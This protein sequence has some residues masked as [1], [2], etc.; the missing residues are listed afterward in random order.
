MKHLETSE[1]KSQQ[2][3]KKSSVFWSKWS[4]DCIIQY[5]FT[6]MKCKRK[7]PFALNLKLSK[8]WWKYDAEL[9]SVISSSWQQTFFF[10]LRYFLLF[11]SLFFKVEGTLVSLWSVLFWL[12]HAALMKKPSDV[13]QEP[14]YL[15]Y[16]CNRVAGVNESRIQAQGE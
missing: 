3:N 5:N 1:L 15:S 6:L 2:S 12:G 10:F 14:E 13:Q 11:L 4:Q 16:L 7:I 8:C 9:F